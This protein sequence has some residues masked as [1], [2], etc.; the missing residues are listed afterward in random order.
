MDVAESR[1]Q[2]RDSRSAANTT[3]IANFVGDLGRGMIVVLEVRGG[4]CG[5]A[6]EAE[7]D[8][9]HRWAQTHSISLTPNRHFA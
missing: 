9:H 6:V 1:S 3:H 4:F 8:L 5:V 2:L 7:D